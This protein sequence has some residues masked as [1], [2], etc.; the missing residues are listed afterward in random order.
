MH[1]CYSMVILSFRRLQ[2]IDQLYPLYRE[3][4]AFFLYILEQCKSIL[5]KFGFSKKIIC[6]HI[7]GYLQHG[8]S[9]KL[10]LPHFI[11]VALVP[12]N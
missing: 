4:I 11:G 1:K 2:H 7:V 6:S 8:H 9:G 12:I 10:R 5:A 3:A